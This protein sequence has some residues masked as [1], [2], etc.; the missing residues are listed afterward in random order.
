MSSSSSSTT[1]DHSSGAAAANP[2]AVGRRNHTTLTTLPVDMY[3]VIH[4]FTSIN[5]LLDTCKSMREIGPELR[6]VKLN[7]YYSLQYYNDSNFR[8]RVNAS[9]L[10]TK[11]QL[12]LEF[13]NNAEISDTSYLGHVHTLNLSFCFGIR[14]VSSLGHVHTLDL[15]HCSRIRDVSALGQVPKLT[16]KSSGTGKLMH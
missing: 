13:F 2:R 3:R 16:L 10:R 14:D 12:S 15:S 8:M 4:E 5:P 1:V 11:R 9:V 7:A 6:Y